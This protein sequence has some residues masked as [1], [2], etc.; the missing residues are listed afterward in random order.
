MIVKISVYFEND[1]RVKPEEL[2]LLTAHLER[3]MEKQIQNIYELRNFKIKF[4]NEQY[5]F[6]NL[7][8]KQVMNRLTKSSLSEKKVVPPKGD[9]PSIKF[10]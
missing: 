8:R 4:G 3:A 6:K 7:T 9:T 2:E 5:H 10:K 1:L